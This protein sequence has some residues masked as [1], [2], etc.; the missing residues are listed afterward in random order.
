MIGSLKN[1]LEIIKTENNS[2]SF[3]G[4]EYKTEA[5]VNRALTIENKIAKKQSK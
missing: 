2:F 3:N 5:S 1:N 4:K